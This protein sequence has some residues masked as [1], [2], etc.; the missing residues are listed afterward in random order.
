[1]AGTVIEKSL[2]EIEAAIRHIINK[3]R[4]SHVLVK[5]T[6]M[7]NTLC[8]CL[9]VI[10][11]TEAAAYD[12]LEHSGAAN[13]GLSYVYAYGIFQ[14][15]QTQQDAVAALRML[16][17]LKPQRTLALKRIRDLRVL[18]V[19]HPFRH[20]E[21]GIAKFGFIARSS[22]SKR[23]FRL[24]VAYDDDRPS[25]FLEVD[26]HELIADQRRDLSILLN[27]VLNRLIARDKESLEQFRDMKLAKIFHP[28]TDW[29][30]GHVESAVVSAD[31]RPIALVDLQLIKESVNL[32]IGALSDRGDHFKD[33]IKYFVRP[34]LHAID[35]LTAFFEGHISRL[36]EADADIF[37][38]WL[39][40]HLS[41]TARQ[42]AE[43]DSDYESGTA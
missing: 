42:A 2:G 6:N 28:T 41:D 18:S 39:R 34:A 11:D 36:E 12:F 20:K 29:M 22:L 19:A 3:P 10:G 35:R 23:G 37:A 14:I 9:D 21:D 26:V 5:D 16:V 38:H 27:E 17:D 7:W 32:Y 15:L 30:M 31:E 4:N 8:C 40:R 43:I 13:I 33:Y 24:M 25:K 1:M